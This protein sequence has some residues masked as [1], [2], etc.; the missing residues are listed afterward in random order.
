[1]STDDKTASP[2]DAKGA[3]AAAKGRP[4]DVSGKPGDAKT[5]PA[6]R[7]TPWFRLTVIVLFALLYAY[8]LFEA[9]SD[10]FGVAAQITKYNENATLIGLN[11][12]AIPWGVLIANLL[13][14]VVVFGLCILVARKRNVGILVITLLAGLGVVGALSLSFSVLAGALA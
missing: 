4:A 2:A 12:V 14:P 13:L 10:T 11:T 1:M 8:D 7:K 3:P 5:K 6:V 9:L